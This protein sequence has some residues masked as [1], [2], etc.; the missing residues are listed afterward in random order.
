MSPNSDQYSNRENNAVVI[1][2]A[3]RGS[4]M[5]SS[6]NGPKQYRSI[7]ETSV[8]DLTIQAFVG[9]SL[10]EFVQVVIHPDDEAMYREKVTPHAKLRFPVFGGKTRQESAFAGLKALGDLN[11]GKVLIHD[12]ARPFVNETIISNVIDFIS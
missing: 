4:R 8:L 10:I 3:G 2:A 7:G 11:I 12:G 5:G 6:G 9:S 1:V